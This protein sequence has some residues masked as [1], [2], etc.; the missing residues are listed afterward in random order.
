MASVYGVCEGVALEEIGSG[1]TEF[2]AGP[3]ISFARLG[4]QTW[5]RQSPWGTCL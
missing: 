3:W 2:H 4:A 5:T 1:Q